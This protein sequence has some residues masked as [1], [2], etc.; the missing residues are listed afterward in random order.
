MPHPHVFAASTRFCR[1]HTCLL[2]PHAFAESQRVCRICIYLS[3]IHVIA[4]STR[5]RVCC[6]PTFFITLQRY[7]QIKSIIKPN[8]HILNQ[9]T[10]Y[11][12]SSTLGA[13]FAQQGTNGELRCFRS[14]ANWRCCILMVKRGTVHYCSTIAHDGK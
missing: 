7:G 4:A 8:R 9:T 11:S 3:H 12:I 5:A 14:H 13:H 10:N 1:I 2:H 6:T